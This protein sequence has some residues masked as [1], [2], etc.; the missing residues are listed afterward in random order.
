MPSPPGSPL[1]SKDD[2]D[3]PPTPEELRAAAALREA[4]TATEAPRPPAQGA[5]PGSRP[6]AASEE[7][8]WL[9]AHLR[10]PSADDSLGE[11]RARGISRAAREVVMNRRAQ[12]RSRGWRQ[13]GRSVTGTG[14]LIAAAAALLVVSWGLF[15]QGLR[16]Q[17]GLVRAVPRTTTALLLGASLKH[18]ESPTQRLDLMIQERLLQLRAAPLRAGGAVLASRRAPAA[19]MLAELPAA[20]SDHATEGRP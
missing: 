12:V 11:V 18:K 13:L 14:G 6:R 7:A 17:R 19:V 3:A 1:P 4:L 8:R 20:P 5:A 10:L 9:A 15:D 2:P 16:L